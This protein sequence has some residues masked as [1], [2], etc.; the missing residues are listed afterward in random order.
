MD[1]DQFGQSFGL[2]LDKGK[3]RLTSKLGTCCSFF[4]AIVLVAYAGY[5]VSILEG[6]KG[7][8]ILTS[9]SKNHFDEEYTFGGEQGLN[10]AV[11][12]TD[13]FDKE[14]Y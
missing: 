4:L 7:V 11:A 3:D 1:L 9:V 6:K 2:Q 12:V 13:S 5:K 10:L 14:S 8:D